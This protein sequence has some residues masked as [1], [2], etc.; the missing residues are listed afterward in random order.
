[1]T[2]KNNNDDRKMANSNEII[3]LLEKI[4]FIQNICQNTLESIMQG[5]GS[6]IQFQFHFL[7]H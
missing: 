5:L 4:D 1:M 3:A 7:F 6:L 2:D